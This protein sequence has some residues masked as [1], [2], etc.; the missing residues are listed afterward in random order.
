M[1]ATCRRHT[2]AHISPDREQLHIFK[3]R[4]HSRFATL[5]GDGAVVDRH[6]PPKG[7]PMTMLVAVTLFQIL[8]MLLGRPWIVL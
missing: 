2:E 7:I 1:E 8:Y 4:R 3:T 5:V 6:P